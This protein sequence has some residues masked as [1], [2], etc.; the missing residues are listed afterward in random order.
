MIITAI[1]TIIRQTI[2]ADSLNGTCFCIQLYEAIMLF[3]QDNLGLGH[4]LKELLTIKRIDL[5]II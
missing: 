1:R 4:Q 5:D 3:I 2:F